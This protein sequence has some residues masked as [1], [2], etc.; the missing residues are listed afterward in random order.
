MISGLDGLVNDYL[1]DCFLRGRKPSLNS[2]GKFIGASRMT[3]KHVCLGC[4]ADGRPYTDKPSANRA[5]ANSDFEMIR[6]I[7]NQEEG[8]QD[9]G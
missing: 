6:N 1:D 4:Y 2:L 9:N 5:I 3:I 7:F 8:G